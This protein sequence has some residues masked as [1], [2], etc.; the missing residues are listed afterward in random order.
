ME[1]KKLTNLAFAVWAY[2]SLVLQSNEK[3]TMV[4][5]KTVAKLLMH[6]LFISF[7]SATLKN[8]YNF[9]LEQYL[10]KV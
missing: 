3:P 7:D 8:Q 4:G 5:P 9:I 10:N 2:V 1:Y 6:I